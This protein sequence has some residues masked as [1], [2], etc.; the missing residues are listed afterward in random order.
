MKKRT[1]VILT[2]LLFLML[3]MLNTALALGR[4]LD[5]EEPSPLHMG[6]VYPQVQWQ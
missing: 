1:I 5:E 6:H 2:A 4:G 3:V